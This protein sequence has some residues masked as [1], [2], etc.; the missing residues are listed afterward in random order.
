MVGRPRPVAIV[1]TGVTLILFSIPFIYIVAMT[2]ISPESYYSD[3]TAFSLVNL[4]LIINPD[5]ARAVSISLISSVALNIS[6][7]FLILYS[8][9]NINNRLPIFPANNDPIISTT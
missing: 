5:F 2:F 6:L 3:K 7:V 4:R 1:V 9:S 8:L